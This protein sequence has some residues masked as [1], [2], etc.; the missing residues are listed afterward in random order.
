MDD[1]I[2][3]VFFGAL[4]LLSLL[5][6]KK[7]KKRQQQQQR[8]RVTRPT[9]E[10]IERERAGRVPQESQRP[11]RRSP[12]QAK[13]AEPQAEPKDLASELMKLLQGQM[14]PEPEPQRA[15]PEPEPYDEAE[16]LEELEIS[17]TERHEEF[18]EKYFDE[19][20]I[21]PKKLRAAAYRRARIEFNNKSLRHAFVMKEVLGPPKGLE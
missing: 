16:S 11:V 7:K 2:S 5:S 18:H 9:P 21:Q 1:L 14:T 19:P 6:G 4:I 10:R 3:L 12:A 17:S 20:A 15:P 13:A 8:P